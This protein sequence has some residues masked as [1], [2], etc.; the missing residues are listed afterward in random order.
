MLLSFKHYKLNIVIC[1]Q[2]EAVLELAVVHAVGVVVALEVLLPGVY[3]EE[4]KVTPNSHIPLEPIRY[5]MSEWRDLRLLITFHGART[6]Q[7]VHSTY[8]R[9][10]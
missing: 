3:S 6:I 4:P 8:L 5:S 9:N 10:L 7:Q 1:A 2:S